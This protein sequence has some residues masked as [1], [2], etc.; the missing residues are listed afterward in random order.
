[1]LNLLPLK[2]GVYKRTDTNL[3]CIN[4]TST[5]VLTHTLVGLVCSRNVKEKILSELKTRYKLQLRC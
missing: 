4:I 5:S 2:T 1:M 3:S